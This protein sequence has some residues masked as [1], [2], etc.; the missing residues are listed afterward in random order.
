MQAVKSKFREADRCASAFVASLSAAERRE[1]PYRHWIAQDVL[2]LDVAARLAALPFDPPE[3]DGISGARELHNNTR[4]Y[5]DPA[6]IARFPVCAAVAESFQ[7]ETVT[8]AI[9]Q[10]TG[11]TL[12]G[13]Y[14]RIEYAQDTSGFWLKPHTDLGV[15]KFTLLYYLGPDQQPELGTDVY[16]D[17]DTWAARIPF[18]PGAGMIFVPSDRT[19]HGFEPRMIGGVRKSLIINYVTDEWRA[20]EQLAFPEDT[21]G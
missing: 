11:A 6:A 17:G 10:I 7:S 13:T 1:S 9:E 15:K 14:L 2:P 16:A 18:E 12:S 19:W 20:R 4:R 5:L 3:L 8:Q 21:I